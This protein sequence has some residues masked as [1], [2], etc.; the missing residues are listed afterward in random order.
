MNS[1]VIISTQ[2]HCPEILQTMKQDKK[3]TVTKLSDTA[4]QELTGFVCVCNAE[5]EVSGSVTTLWA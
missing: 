5:S 2:A 4:W 1:V 3:E